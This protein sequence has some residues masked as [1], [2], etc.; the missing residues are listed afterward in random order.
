VPGGTAR[1]TLDTVA[2]VSALGGVEQIGVSAWHRGPAPADW[3]P[4]IPVRA[5]PLPRVLL[6]DAWQRLRRPVVERATGPVDLVHATG[7]VAAASRAPLV[8]NI[9]DLSFL[10]DPS[11]FTPRGISVFNRFLD[12]V[13]TDAAMVVCPSEAT[14]DDCVAA[15]IEAAR[16]RVA[17]LGTSA[18]Q[19]G[20]AEVDEVRARYSLSRPYVLFVGTVEPRKNLGRLLEAFARLGEVDAELVMVGPDGWNTDLPD[21][22]VRRL[23]FVPKADLDGLY[24]GA[25]VV[26]YPSLREGFGLPVLDAM[27]QGAAVV[28]SATTSTAEVAGDA[29]L[30]VDPLD[31]DAIAGALQ[32]LL[33]DPDLA[34]RLGQTARERAAT[35]TWERTAQTVVDAYTD[36]LGAR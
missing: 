29:A 8:V 20:P 16:V 6:Y 32:R 28:T 36:V 9:Y 31:V 25:S 30:L 21:T 22:P 27:A 26:A 2:A 23:G 12:L 3:R 15:G 35:F 19:A 34:R 14:R 13:R 7:H 5:L 4:T 10:H 24:A 33:H 1:A 11:H 17:P 18:R